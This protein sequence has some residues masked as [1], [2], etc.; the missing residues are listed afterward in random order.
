MNYPIPISLRDDLFHAICE[1]VGEG[2]FGDKAQAAVDEA[3]SA[4]RAIWLRLPGAADWTLAQ[5]CRPGCA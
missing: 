2:Y 5:D 3:V 1:R 4:W